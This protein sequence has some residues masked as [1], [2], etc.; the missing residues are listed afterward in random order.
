M[1]VM[2]ANEGVSFCLI[3]IFFFKIFIGFNV[4][5]LG[6][7]DDFDKAVSLHTLIKLP[8]HKRT[9]ERRCDIP[10]ISAAELES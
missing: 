1:V 2:L 6:G 9:S 3:T 8:M 7:S 10:D 5:F 4:V